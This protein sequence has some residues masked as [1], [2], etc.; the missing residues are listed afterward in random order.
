MAK[1]NFVAVVTFMGRKV[2]SIPPIFHD[3]KFITDF[4]EKA[5][6]FN[7][8][9]ASHCALITNTS[10]LPTNCKSFTD[11]SL[12]KYPLLIMTLGK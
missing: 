6:L 3:N 11:K 2:P 1:N 4:R 7:S 9:F 12:S 8:F 5:E 10:E